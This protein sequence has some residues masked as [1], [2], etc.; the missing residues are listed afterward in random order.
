MRKLITFLIALV[1]TA[2][3]V[4]ATLASPLDVMNGFPPGHSR[5]GRRLTPPARRRGRPD[6]HRK[7]QR[8]SF[9][10]SRDLHERKHRNGF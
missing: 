6:I 5:A 4:G 9:W 2:G 7:C 8:L 3:A 1:I 10:R